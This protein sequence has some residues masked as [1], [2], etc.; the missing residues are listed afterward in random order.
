MCAV[1]G[2]DPSINSGTGRSVCIGSRYSG[3]C[4]SSTFQNP[5]SDSY[6]SNLKLLFVDQ[7]PWP[8]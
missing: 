7:T 2:S 3:C 4:G 8:S 5:V 1:L 6:L